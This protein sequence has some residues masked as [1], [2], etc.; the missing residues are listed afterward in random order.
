MKA[1]RCS[2]G[3]TPVDIISI[4]MKSIPKPTRISPIWFTVCFLENIARA[5]PINTAIGA[6][7]S[8][9]NTPAH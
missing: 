6:K 7:F 3:S 4:P 9:L 5:A 1:G 8:G 2:K